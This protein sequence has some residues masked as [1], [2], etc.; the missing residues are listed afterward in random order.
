MPN[1]RLRLILA[2]VYRTGERS[3]LIRCWAR[4]ELS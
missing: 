2:G 3:L 4:F 1:T